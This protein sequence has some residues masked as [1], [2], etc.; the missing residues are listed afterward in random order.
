MPNAHFE[1][2]LTDST[3]FLE[4]GKDQLHF[5]FTA[6]KGMRAQE[7]KK[8]ASGGEL[9]RIM[10]AIKAVLSAYAQL[11]TLIFD[12]IDT[13]VSGEIALKMGNIMKA[14]GT[15]MQLISITHL[16]Q[17][18][19]KGAQHFKVYK[20][21]IAQKTTTGIRVLTK[22]ER[23]AELA[24]MLGGKASSEAAFDHA[25]QLLNE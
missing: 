14:M 6:N 23:I 7:L 3:S 13:G 12:E 25:R 10:L 17:I 21:D 11:P 22:E 18:A 15:R 8:A 16:P 2:S 4:N 20:E 1:V 5:L 24:E 9:S 19:G